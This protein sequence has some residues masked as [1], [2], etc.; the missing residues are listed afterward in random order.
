MLT[1]LDCQ[2]AFTLI[3]LV[4][5]PLDQAYRHG[6][7]VGRARGWKRERWSRLCWHGLASVQP[8]RTYT[9]AHTHTISNS[10][11]EPVNCPT[12][13]Q[14]GYYSD[15]QLYSKGSSTL[16]AL[17]GQ[18]KATTS[19]SLENT[20]DNIIAHATEFR[21]FK[22]TLSVNEGFSPFVIHGS[23]K[24]H[25]TWKGPLTPHI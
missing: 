24:L 4:C 2:R 1:K 10:Q 14:M 18:L 25:P 15:A 17:S 21:V 23:K 3:L 7:E 22:E 8:A 20:G 13:V 5:R 9:R 19:L 11:T 6:N 16:T 12:F